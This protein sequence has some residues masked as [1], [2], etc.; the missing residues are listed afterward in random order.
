MH[1]YTIYIGHECYAMHMHS[2]IIQHISM[3]SIRYAH[4]SC[5]TNFIPMNPFILYICQSRNAVYQII[6]ERMNVEMNLNIR[7]IYEQELL[8][9]V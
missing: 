2:H 3:Y 1:I 4:Y 9:D 7:L 6:W 8:S 5:I